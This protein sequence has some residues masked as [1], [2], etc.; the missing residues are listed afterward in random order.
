MESYF[1]ETYRCIEHLFH[2]IAEPFYNTLKT[3]LSLTEVSREIEDK[4]S[5]R[6]NEESTLE[7]IFKEIEPLHIAADLKIIKEKSDKNMK[8]GKWYYQQRNSIAHYRAIHTP[9]KY[10]NKEWNV[11][12]CFNFRVMEYLYDKYKNVI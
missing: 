5:W 3:S 6:P 4:I 7:D 8:M 11:L 9:L 2:T 12:I 10:D 1:L